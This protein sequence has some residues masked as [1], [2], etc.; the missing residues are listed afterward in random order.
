MFS[1]A[2]YLNNYSVQQ[3]QL[4]PYSIGCS[5]PGVYGMKCDTD[6]PENCRYKTCHIKNGIC[7]GCE[8]GYNGT[9]CIT[10]IFR[11]FLSLGKA[12][13]NITFICI[14]RNRF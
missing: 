2:V 14:C 6:C 11:S 7:F 10:G 8:A 3:N 13:M 4:Y 1:Y 9:F 12:V 5:K